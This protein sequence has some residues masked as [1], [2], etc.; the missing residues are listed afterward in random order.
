M[1]KENLDRFPYFAHKPKAVGIYLLKDNNG[2]KRT[3]CKVCSKLALLLLASFC[4]L[5]F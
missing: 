4:C 3:T 1:R 5:Y 2:N